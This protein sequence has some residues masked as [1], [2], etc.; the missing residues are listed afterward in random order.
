MSR[1]AKVHPA[2][3]S[4]SSSTLVKKVYL[5]SQARNNGE[6]LRE[7]RQDILDHLMNTRKM[8]TYEDLMATTDGKYTLPACLFFLASVVW[9]DERLVKGVISTA[10][11][12]G[13]LHRLRDTTYGN[14][15]RTL[16]SM[17]Q[18]EIILDALERNEFPEGRMKKTRRVSSRV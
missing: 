2:P 10:K 1:R 4:P 14:T 7:Y 11:R 17:A 16:R 12:L 8:K 15:R 3:P 5:Y 18:N 13:V 6:T 9:H